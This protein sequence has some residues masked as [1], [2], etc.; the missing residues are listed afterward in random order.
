MPSS[1]VIQQHSHATDPSSSISR[2]KKCTDDIVWFIHLPMRQAAMALGMSC[3]TI[4][5]TCR[6]NGIQRWPSRKIGALDR[7]IAKLEN[8]MFLKRDRVKRAK[9][10]D[11]WNK[12]SRERMDI[13]CYFMSLI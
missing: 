11:E 7:K 4:Q 5:R 3:A 1:S 13:Y 9:M 10:L 12:L 8:N 6:R 2:R